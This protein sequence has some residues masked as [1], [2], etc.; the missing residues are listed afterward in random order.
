LHKK[1]LTR[2]ELQRYYASREDPERYAKTLLAK[3]E[4]RERSRPMRRLR[5]AL[6]MT[7]RA[8]IY[9]AL[10]HKKARSPWQGLVGYT[11]DEL[12]AYL[13]TKFQEG[14]TWDNHG[15]WHIDHIRPIS[16]FSFTSSDDDEFKQC[17]AL[18][19]LQPLWAKDNL[20]KKRGYT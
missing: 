11:V 9:E 17:W 8:R 20:S 3:Q 15:E 10:K 12:R 6:C 5:R 2:K 1:E 14:M 16:S 19:N 4:E 13:E 7:M 18:E